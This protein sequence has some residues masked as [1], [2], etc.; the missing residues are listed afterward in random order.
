MN[1]YTHKVCPVILR[2]QGDSWQILAFRHPLAG[3][4]LMK[5][6]L[7]DGERP[8]SAVLREL[9]EESG[10][11]QAAVIEKIGEL[12]LHEAEQHWHIFWCELAAWPPDEWSFFTQDGG[13]LLFRFFW[14]PLTEDPDD[15]WHPVFRRPL[16][17][18]RAWH[19]GIGSGNKHPENV[20]LRPITS[21]NWYECTQLA[22][23]EEQRRIGF[24]EP[25]Y[26]SLAQA[27]AERWWQPYAIY[28]G[29]TMIGFAMYGRWPATGLPAHHVYASPGTDFILRFMI[30]GRYQGQGYGRRRHGRGRLPRSKPSLMRATI[31]ISYD[32][33]NTAMVRLCRR[34]GFQPTG[35]EIGGE[36]EAR[37]VLKENP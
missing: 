26:G 32:A 2:R 36:V 13:G 12:D 4:Q 3:T 35:R 27:Y 19:Q 33:I 28:A 25:N 1:P 20:T 16:A 14:R 8:E 5:G 7:E 11:D 9:A 24:V 10:I 30:D 15:T 18:I 34:V 29:E 37:L 22:P 23:T 31:E 21:D 6:T 17:Y